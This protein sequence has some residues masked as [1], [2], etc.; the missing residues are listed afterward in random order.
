MTI[1]KDKM[2]VE[3]LSLVVM[4]NAKTRKRA[5]GLIKQGDVEKVSA[6]MWEILLC[7][8]DHVDLCDWDKL[9]GW[10]WSRILQNYPQYADKCRW[11]KLEVDDWLALVQHQPQF[12]DHPMYRLKML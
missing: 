11:D 4:R 3:Q 1:S 10:N 6:S 5:L 7:W 9:H 2:S 12:K 8:G